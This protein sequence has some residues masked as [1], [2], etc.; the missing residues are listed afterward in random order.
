M[1]STMKTRWSPHNTVL[2]EQSQKFPLLTHVCIYVS[3][4]KENFERMVTKTLTVV[5]SG[6]ALFP[7]TVSYHFTVFL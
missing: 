1:G 3:G 4:M 6:W 5:I 2:S 7:F